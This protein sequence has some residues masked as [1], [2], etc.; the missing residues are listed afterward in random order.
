MNTQAFTYL[1]EHPENISSVHTSDIRSLID[2]F[3][4]FQ[5]AHALYIKGL[6]NQESFTYNKALKVTAAHT[7]DRS[8]LFEY[9]TSDVFIQNEI[10]TQIKQQ[11]THLRALQ[12][13]NLQDVSLQVQEEEQEKASKILDPNLFVEKKDSEITKRSPKEILSVGKPLDFDQNEVHS[14]QE[15]LQL[16]RFSPIKREKPS[17]EI[18]KKDTLPKPTETQNTDTNSKKRKQDIVDSF[19]ES[20]PKI[21]FSPTTA[22]PKK[23]LAKESLIPSEALMTETLARVYVE[24]KNF[25][26]A[27][28]AYRILSLKYPEKS[29]FFADQIRAVEQLEEK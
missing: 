26:K 15:W 16:S 6:K 13:E 11:E 17:S 7:T 29:G 27:K 20:N 12:V 19:I 1:L 9:I 8:V 2:D 28:Q 23:N 5:S 22:P 25:K 14:F 10:S 4:Y 3:P 21:E 18:I 24:Q